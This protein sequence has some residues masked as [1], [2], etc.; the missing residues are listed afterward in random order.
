MVVVVVDPCLVVVVRTEVV[1]V[2]VEVVVVVGQTVSAPRRRQVR[3]RWCRHFSERLGPTTQSR[4]A[5]IQHRCACLSSR[6]AGLFWLCCW[7]SNLDC[8]AQ[9]EKYRVSSSSQRPRTAASQRM[10]QV[11]AI[12]GC[13]ADAVPKGGRR[14]EQEAEGG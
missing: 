5:L 7:H 14:G 13:N 6:F 9:R 3:R 2:E 10:S 1:V 8:C 12:C 4:T 11:Q